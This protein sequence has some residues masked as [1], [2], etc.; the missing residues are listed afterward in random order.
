MSAQKKAKKMSREALIAAYMSTTLEEE[1]FPTSVYKF[2][3]ELK[4]DE[5]DFYAHFG[6][7]EGL[8][9]GIWISF[10]NQTYALLEKD[11]SFEEYGNREKML[12]FFFT[13]FELLGLNRSYVLFA[14]GQQSQPM[15]RMDQLKGLRKA[16]RAFA[17]EL[18]E[19][20]NAER[21]S[22]ITRRNPE[23]FSEGAWLQ[24]LFLLRFWSQMI[25]QALKKP[26]W[27]LKNL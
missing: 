23:V 25:P 16:V 20:A 26:T 9:K 27:P 14:L 5:A 22:R 18:I 13:F 21:P 12:S 24:L 11:S 10:F 2:C 3:K 8:Q 15:Q 6:S 1:R 19:D 17:K 7:L 4:I